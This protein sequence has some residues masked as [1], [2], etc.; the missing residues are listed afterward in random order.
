MWNYFC[1]AWFS[2]SHVSMPQPRAEHSLSQSY[3]NT[4]CGGS[5]M[6]MLASSGFSGAVVVVSLPVNKWLWPL[7]IRFC[8]SIGAS[9]GASMKHWKLGFY[10]IRK[11]LGHI[12]RCIQ[13]W[14][15]SCCILSMVMARVCTVPN[16]TVRKIMIRW[17]SR[18]S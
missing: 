5:T 15:P 18:V 9:I 13:M 8:A 12:P 14:I 7:L 6:V 3:D 17:P 10:T 4:H 1:C 16:R 2:K 11:T